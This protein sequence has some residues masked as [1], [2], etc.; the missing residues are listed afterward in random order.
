MARTFELL[1]HGPYS[2]E[3]GIDATVGWLSSQAGFEALKRG[4]NRA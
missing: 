1:G 2:F 3:Q 4:D